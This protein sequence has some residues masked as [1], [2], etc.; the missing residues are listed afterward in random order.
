MCR[1]DDWEL[2]F[3]ELSVFPE[4]EVDYTLHQ[5]ASTVNVLTR[6]PDKKLDVFVHVILNC[7]CQKVMY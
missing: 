1:I 5:A 2:F 7:A 4:T 3:S 6:L